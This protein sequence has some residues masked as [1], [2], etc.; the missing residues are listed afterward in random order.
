MI[1]G[2]GVD[3]AEIVR[4]ERAHARFGARFAARILDHQELRGLGA[5]RNPARYLAMRFAA[6]EA[7]S[8]ALGTGFKQGVAPRQIG[9]VHAPSGKPGLAVSGMAATLFER[10]GIVASHVSLS[11]DGGFA[12]AYVVLEAQLPPG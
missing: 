12:I 3:I 7:T 6:K 2:I 10:H 4:F 5:A 9:V 1:Y 11:D 8:K